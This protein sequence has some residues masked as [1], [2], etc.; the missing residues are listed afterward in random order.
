MA[1]EKNILKS[2][3]KNVEILTKEK[4]RRYDAE[5]DAEEEEKKQQEKHEAA[6]KEAERKKKEEE[7]KK[8]IEKVKRKGVGYVTNEGQVWNIQKYMNDREARNERVAS[9]L[10]LIASL[11][12]SEDWSP[13]SHHVTPLLES[14]L[15]PLMESTFSAGSLVNLVKDYPLVMA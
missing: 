12:D 8:N 1:L 5:Y 11:F 10:N 7:A 14:C 9:F 2:V 15:L 6:M 4:P 3:L 13:E